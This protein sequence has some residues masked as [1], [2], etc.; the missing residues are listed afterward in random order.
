[1]KY[2][3]N[4]HYLFDLEHKIMLLWAGIEG[5]FQVDAEQSRRIALYSA[6]LMGGNEQARSERFELV[7]KSYSL[8]SRVVHGAS[9]TKDKLE[10]GYADAT[11]LLADLLSRCVEL[12]RVPSRDE[13]D[14]ASFSGSLV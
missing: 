3:G 9:P 10:A 5:L 7:K 2:F 8:R 13:L 1:M 4:A 14:R 12:G 6:M 11:N